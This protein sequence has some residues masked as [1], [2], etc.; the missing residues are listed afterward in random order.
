MIIDAPRGEILHGGPDQGRL[1][2]ILNFFHFLIIA[3]A[4]VV[5]S[6]SCLAIFLY[7]IPALSRSTVLSLMSSHS[8]LVLAMV[9]RLEFVCQVKFSVDTN[10]ANKADSEKTIVRHKNE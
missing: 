9:E 5:F 3:P 8:S 10:L 2:I 1:T 6:P 4:V 7:T